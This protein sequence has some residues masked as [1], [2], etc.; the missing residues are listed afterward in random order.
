MGRRSNKSHK[1]PNV[2]L[3]PAQPG[4]GTG[5]TSR[6]VTEE[7]SACWAQETQETTVSDMCPRPFKGVVLCATGIQDKPTLF[8]QASELGATTTHPFTNRITHL[9]AENHGGAKYWCAVERQI[10]ILKPSWVTESYQVW[11]R[12]DDV[13]FE[14]SI[15]AHQLPIFSGVVLSYS[16]IA[17]VRR[18]TEITQKLKQNDGIYMENLERPVKVTHILC[19]GDEETDK[20][21]YARK[22]NQRGEANIYLVWEEW[23]W[24]SLQFGGQFNEAEY[25]V[26][27]PRPQRRKLIA[28]ESSP[29]LA[30]MPESSSGSAQTQTQSSPP[31]EDEEIACV[32]HRP[33]MTLQIWG[34]LLKNRGYEVSNGK[35]IKTASKVQKSQPPLQ[36][37]TSIE[38]ADANGMDVDVSKAKSIISTFRRANSFAPANESSQKSQP[39]HRLQPFRRTT[40]MAAI[41]SQQ[42]P[43][44]NANAEA[45]PSTTGPRGI[46]SGLRFRVLGEARSHNVR[47]AIE[48]GGGIWASE[49]DMDED[50]DYIIVRLVSGSKIYKE[51]PDKLQRTKYRT[52]CWLERCLSEQAVCPYQ[53]HVTFLPLDIQLPA[54]GT[55]SIIVNFSGLLQDESCWLTRL[56]RALGI[57]LANAFSKRTTHLLCPSGTGLKYEKAKEWGIPV[58]S[59][60]WLAVIA[61][62]GK[63]PPASEY[64]VAPGIPG[65]HVGNEVVAVDIKGKGKTVE[66][67]NRQASD[68][69]LWAVDTADAMMNDITNGLL[70]LFLRRFT[71][72]DKKSNTGRTDQ[73]RL[74]CV[75]NRSSSK[76][77]KPS[78]Q[79]VPVPMQQPE[80]PDTGNFSFGQPGGLLGGCPSQ[81]TQGPALPVTPSRKNA[82][83]WQHALIL[84]K[85]RHRGGS[86]ALLYTQPEGDE[87]I[88]AP[89]PS[90]RTPS[91][92][93]LRQEGSMGS[94]AS[95]SPMKIDQALQES[96][97]S[98]LGKRQGEDG[99]GRDG[100]R[101]RPRRGPMSKQSSASS[102]NF[103]IRLGSEPDGIFGVFGP[104]ADMG[105]NGAE[106]GISMDEQEKSVWVMYEDPGQADERRRLM[107]LFEDP[108]EKTQATAIPT[109][110]RRRKSARLGRV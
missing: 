44:G 64:A 86:N 93:K 99:G 1:V 81:E 100:K 87:T 28:D 5:R 45:G 58:V 7:E 4:D 69:F 2:K 101:S 91:P 13:D 88:Q 108:N 20:I 48:Q 95:I 33:A 25:D 8:K 89:V 104:D 59:R 102:L 18:R 97:A 21:H 23:F 72:G 55:E 43:E 107:T 78:E 29:P 17:D 31:E 63:V 9:I 92:L 71:F 70:L 10:P 50:V 39:T 32:A 79:Q 51:D 40:S 57:Q 36:D 66:P 42:L 34:G 30:A 22:F 90:S 67:D 110:K 3:R 82:P 61:I 12:G 15:K 11:L 75:A 68:T 85:H 24:D 53:D 105:G 54:V 6:M 76:D 35:I 37:K 27:G 74:T 19:S 16:G 84:D 46:F 26:Q 65:E 98:L 41:Q 38:P 109:K 77:Q 80:P 83:E 73:A 96:V 14:K 52:E 56:L 47:S 60:E 103:D 62:T 106:S 49:Q 94:V